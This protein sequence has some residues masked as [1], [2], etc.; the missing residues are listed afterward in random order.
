[1]RKMALFV[2]LA[3]MMSFMVGCDGDSGDPSVTF[4][5][6]SNDSLHIKPSKGETTFNG[7]ILSPGEQKTLTGYGRYF[8]EAYLTNGA[9]AED[10]VNIVTED[11]AVYF[12]DKDA[13]DVSSTY[14]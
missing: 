5:N 6:R 9:D 12:I 1:M 4:Y 10:E 8:F 3:A 13:K 14:N 11:G 2:A 7:F